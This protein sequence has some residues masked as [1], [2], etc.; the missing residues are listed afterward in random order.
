MNIS[1]KKNK[2]EKSNQN[3]WNKI[4]KKKYDYKIFR[5]VNCKSLK[6]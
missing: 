3:L 6:N 2:Q 1:N 5:N 4:Y